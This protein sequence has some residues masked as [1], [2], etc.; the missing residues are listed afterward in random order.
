[1]NPGFECACGKALSTSSKAKHVCKR[2]GVLENND[3]SNGVHKSLTCCFCLHT[4]SSRNRHKCL[5]VGSNK[6]DVNYLTLRD[7]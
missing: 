4:Y 1:M 6:I 7:Y 2:F 3:G 5:A